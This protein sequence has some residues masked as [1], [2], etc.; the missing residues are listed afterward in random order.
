M[1][2]ETMASLAEKK[3]EIRRLRAE[4]YDKNA[5][6][7]A[8]ETDRQTNQGKGFLGVLSAKLCADKNVDCRLFALAIDR[9]STRLNSSHP[10]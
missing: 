3:K 7:A 9:K 10:V 4:L 2:T 6:I 5:V 1:T 8:L